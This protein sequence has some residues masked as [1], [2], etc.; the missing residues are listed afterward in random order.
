[1][2]LIVP[3][4]GDHSQ[5]LGPVFQ[6][7]GEG[8]FQGRSLAPVH[9]VVQQVDLFVCIRRMLK[10]GKIFRLGAVVDQN[11]VRKAVFQEPVDH[12]VQL[13]I[14]VQGGQD[15]RNAR[16]ICHINASSIPSM[17]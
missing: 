17:C 14:R 12:R 3:V 13:L 2:V 1:M 11:N 15:N 9:L 4:H 6:K 7:V 5:P 10:P 8:G 16:K